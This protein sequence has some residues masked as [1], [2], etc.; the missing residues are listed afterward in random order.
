M[1]WNHSIKEGTEMVFDEEDYNLLTGDY[2]FN[3][4]NENGEEKIT[5]GNRGKKKLLKLSQF[6]I[7]DM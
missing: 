6:N 1:G 2:I 7:D 3:K 4:T 5:K